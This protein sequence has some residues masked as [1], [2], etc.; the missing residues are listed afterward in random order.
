MVMQPQRP[1]MP[2]Q[3]P[4]M[5]PPQNP[6]LDPEIAKMYQILKFSKNPELE[7]QNMIK[8]NP[9][10]TQLANLVSSFGKGPEALFYE[11]AKRKGV[12]PNSIIRLFN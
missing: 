7:I 6:Q 8:K 12:D 10:L 3:V 9:Q 5:V 1:V 11:L 2:Q 4:Q